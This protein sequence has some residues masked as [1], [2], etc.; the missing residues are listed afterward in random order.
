MTTHRSQRLALAVAAVLVLAAC[1]SSGSG[2]DEAGGTAAPTTTASTAAAPTTGA[3]STT[4]A[5]APT[6]AA[7]V[8]TEAELAPPT[9]S[10]AEP[11]GPECKRVEDFDDGA[12]GRWFVVNDGVMGGLSQGEVAFADGV[13]TF[14]GVINTNG[15]GFSMV[16]TSSAQGDASLRDVL[17]GAEFLVVRARTT[18]A[19]SY[20]LTAEDAASAGSSLMYFAGIDDPGGGWA[21]VTVPLTNMAGRFFGNDAPDAP[22]FNV[23]QVASLGVILADGI[24]GEFALELDHIDA[25]SA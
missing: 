11:E 24:D 17:E 9:T 8:I 6:T 14:S 18:D 21:E 5:P 7:A 2:V 19:R 10:A 12:E 15:G 4:D 16:R 1:G 3:P 22:P 20:E 23:D 13:M 25:C